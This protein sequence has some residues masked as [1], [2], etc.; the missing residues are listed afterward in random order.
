MHWPLHNCQSIIKS[1]R[2]N[3]PNEMFSQASDSLKEGAEVPEWT[4]ESTAVILCR[5]IQSPT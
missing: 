5:D 3:L 2:E 4:V 1:C